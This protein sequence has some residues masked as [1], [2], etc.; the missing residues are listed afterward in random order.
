MLKRILTSLES[1]VSF[2]PEP[3]S[4]APGPAQG[5]SKIEKRIPLQV[6]RTLKVQVSFLNY[7]EC[8]M[9]VP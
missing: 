9:D 7:D 6:F 4:R 2:G 8:W 1:L 5:Y 3:E